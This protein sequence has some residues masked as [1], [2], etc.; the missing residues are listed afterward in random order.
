M[1]RGAW[2]VTIHWVSKELNV[3]E[4][5]HAFMKHFLKGKIVH[6]YNVFM[7][8]CNVLKIKAKKKKSY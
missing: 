7:S 2:R 6:F 4:H 8:K 3:T 1:D 5:T